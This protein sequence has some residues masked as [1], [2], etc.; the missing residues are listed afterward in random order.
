LPLR[1]G[2]FWL[3][4]S[5]LT[6]PNINPASC[7]GILALD[8]EDFYKRRYLACRQLVSLS[9]GRLSSTE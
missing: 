4:S 5:H 7:I 9:T 2:V 3:Q 8:K 6:H 1:H